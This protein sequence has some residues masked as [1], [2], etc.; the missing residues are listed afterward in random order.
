MLTPGDTL[1]VRSGTYAESLQGTIPGGTSWSSP[2]TVV[3]YP[4]DTVTIQPTSGAT[5]AL[6]FAG[7]MSTISSYKVS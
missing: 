3:A 6:F 1:F 4:G 2:V 7:A 5:R